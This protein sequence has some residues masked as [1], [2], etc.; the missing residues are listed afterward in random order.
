[1]IG[2]YKPCAQCLRLA[3]QQGYSPV[4]YNV[5]FVGADELTRLLGS[6]AEGIIV[7]QVV[8]PPNPQDKQDHLWGAKEYVR[9]LQ[10]YYPEDHPNFVSLEGYINAKVL[11]EGMVRAGRDLNRESFINAIES[12]HDFDLGISNPLSFSAADHQGLERVYFTLFTNGRFVW[13][14]D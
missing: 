14:T 12:I 13:L 1:M 10:Q 3:K 4:F 2:T 8:P 9:R 11:V 6:D 5:S 7:T